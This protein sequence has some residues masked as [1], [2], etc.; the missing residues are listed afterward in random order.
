MRYKFDEI[1]VKENKAYIRG[2][3]TPNERANHINIIVRDQEKKKL[4]TEI[5]QIERPDVGK[6]MFEDSRCDHY[7]FVLIFPL[8]RSD[9]FYITFREYESENSNPINSMTLKVT[10]NLLTVKSYMNYVRH[11]NTFYCTTE[12]GKK[13]ERTEQTDK[14]SKYTGEIHYHLDEVK[15]ADGKVNFRGWAVPKRKNHHIE[16]TIYDTNKNKMESEAF[17][18]HRPDVGMAVFEDRKA[19]MFGFNLSFEI[20]DRE[21]VIMELTEVD[22]DGNRLKHSAVTLKRSQLLIKDKWQH[23]LLSRGYSYMRMNGVKKTF[24]KIAH[25][26]SGTDD[27]NYDKWYHQHCPSKKEL[28]RQN[29]AHFSYEPKVSI[30]VP[31][32]NTPLNFLDEMIQSVKSQTYK[33]W[34]LCLAN[35]SGDNEELNAELKRYAKEDSR[36]KWEALAENK[37]ISG[38]TNAALALATGDFIALLDHDDL[39]SP[40]ALY[41]VV[42]VLNKDKEVD[43][44][45]SDEDKVDMNGE[46]HFQP[47]FKPDF[48]LDFL[49]S[50]NYICHLFVVKKSIVDEIG[51]FRSKYDGA[52]DHDLILRCSEL[53]NK[54]YHIPKV[55]YHWRA[56]MDSTAEHPESKLYAFEAGTRA[57]HDHYE[58]LGIEARVEIGDFYGM[59]HSY[60]K[61]TS[62]PK[63][64]III[65][66][67]DHSDDLK[68]CMDSLDT[69]TYD[70]Y[71]VIIVE[72]NSEEQTTFEYYKELEKVNS[73]VKVVYWE[74]EFNYSAINNFGVSY[75]SGEY[76][77]FLNNDTEVITPDLLE[78]M[79]GYCTREDVGIVGARLFYEDDTVQHAGVIIGLGG[80]AGH[81][82]VGSY[83][84]DPCYVG[85]SL[86]AQDFSA[87]TA[88]CM[89]TKKSLFDEVDGFTEE[90]AVAFNDVDYCLKIRKLGKL[91]VYSPLAQLYHYESKSRGYE[92]TPAKQRRF[93]GEVETF[94]RRWKNVLLKGDPYYN[95]NL[96]LKYGDCRLNFDTASNRRG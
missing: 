16:F 77:L 96:S 64:S 28:A 68:K 25:K 42:K 94:S 67:K 86:C 5:F 47:N 19:D 66:N 82:F 56:H 8:G 83:R 1:Y 78:T 13:V 57:V 10:K 59:Y 63:V 7:G 72:N 24:I 55:L 23:S 92:D 37:G 2:W 60:F 89:M 45:Y 53:A 50:Q 15:I 26:L 76:L 95:P 22:E 43:M 75:A 87:V 71:E 3:A 6:F 84:E 52:Q 18:V 36:I 58:R 12:I 40:D 27:M 49:C 38:N 44:I 79:L 93:D 4:K 14:N 65:P 88:A 35:G 80:V 91:I 69:L 54:I 34:E 33:N 20:G 61:L 70:N 81:I 51:G 39:L 9:E 90:L 48:N 30:I 17:I 21:Q 32:Y 31:V 85:R 29:Q 62:H 73:R 46:K 41:E 11:R 74:H